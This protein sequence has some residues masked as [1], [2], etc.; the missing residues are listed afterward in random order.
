MSNV[1][2]LAKDVALDDVVESIRRDGAVI[3]EDFLSPEGVAEFRRDMAPYL[4]SY[5]HSPGTFEGLQTKRVGAVFAKSRKA[6]DVATHPLFWAR[7][8]G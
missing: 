6:A 7:P 1:S 5:R 8:S 4:D 2:H 3:I